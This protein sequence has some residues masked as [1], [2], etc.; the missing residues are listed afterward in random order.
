[1]FGWFRKDRAPTK[2]PDFRS[3][4]SPAKA[5]E[6]VR[7]GQF[8]RIMLL[9]S[10]FGGEDIAPNCVF[11]PAWA[12]EKKAGIDNNIVRKLVSEGKVSRYRASPKYQGKSFVPSAITIVASDPGSFSITINIWGDALEQE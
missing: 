5:A 1:M 4:D 8:Q 9:P 11:V 6:L 12:A 2:G 7:V 10:E 3:V